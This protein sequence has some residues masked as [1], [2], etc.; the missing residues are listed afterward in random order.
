M[1]NFTIL[2][3]SI[4]RDEDIDLAQYIIYNASLESN[5]TPSHATQSSSNSSNTIS[6]DTM[7][8][9]AIP[10]TLMS[11]NVT[12]TTSIISEVILIASPSNDNDTNF[13]IDCEL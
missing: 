8:T 12:P 5:E 4:A 11:S 1:N 6:L 9:N 2:D 13:N 7:S 10:T 3:N